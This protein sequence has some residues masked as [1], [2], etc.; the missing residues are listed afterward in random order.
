MKKCEIRKFEKEK[1]PGLPK[2][3]NFLDEM[4]G[5]VDGVGIENDGEFG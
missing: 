4:V 2:H 3:P 1:I 5:S